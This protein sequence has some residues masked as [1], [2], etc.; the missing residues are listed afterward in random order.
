MTSISVVIPVLNDS[1]MLRTCL[2]ALAAQTRPADEIVVVD[3]GSTDDSAAVARAAGARVILQ[4]IRGIFPATA[5]GFDAATGDVLARLDAD[6]IPPAD[7]LARIETL[8][9]DSDGL[10][11][12]TGPGDFYGGSAVVRFLGRKLY[13]GGLFWS[14]NILLGHPPL[15]GSNFAMP[16][17]IWRRVRGVVNSDVRNVHDDLDLSWHLEPDMNVMLVR[18]LSV[19]IS[20]RPFSSLSAL[21]RR[22]GW[23]W[24]TLSLDF[25]EQS[26]FERL[27]ARREWTE[28]PEQLAA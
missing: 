24:T 22:V 13:I 20:A 7:W 3:N 6:S 4:P 14:M 21:G 11:A 16:A 26:P 18:D 17:A 5:A 8:L 1:A 27:R 28:Q 10:T 23:V 25:R 12:V 9:A 15:F 19:G 2:E